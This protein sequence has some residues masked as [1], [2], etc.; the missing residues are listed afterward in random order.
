M[1]MPSRSTLALALCSFALRLPAG[2]ALRGTVTDERGSALPGTSVSLAGPSG[3]R[4][5]VA[6]PRG[7]YNFYGLPPGRYELAYTLDG[8]ATGVIRLRIRDGMTRRFDYK[9]CQGCEVVTISI[10]DLYIDPFSASVLTNRTME[11]LEVFPV[12]RS[13]SDWFGSQWP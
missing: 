10:S 2:G 1:K 3:R 5:L 9:M 13:L 4:S 7:Q 12:C 11:E 8:Y 6:S